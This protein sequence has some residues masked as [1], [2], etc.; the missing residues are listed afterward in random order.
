EQAAMKVLYL[1]VR[2]LDP[3][4]TGQKRWTMRWKPILNVL[5]VSFRDRMPDAANL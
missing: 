2:S 5:G 4:G 3:K 1:A